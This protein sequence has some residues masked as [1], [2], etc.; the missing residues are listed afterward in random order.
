M[1]RS[2]LLALAAMLAVAMTMP[3]AQAV[4][5]EAGCPVGPSSPGWPDGEWNLWSNEDL[6]RA[7][8]E[9]GWFD[10]ETALAAIAGKEDKNGDGFVC[11]KIQSGEKWN[12]NS[13]NA[14]LDYFVYRD[15]SSK[16]N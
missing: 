15:N 9:E 7:I 2:M 6:A 10:Y 14:G 16:A 4:P 3:V 1:R 12:P 11:A 5:P 13:P 8:A